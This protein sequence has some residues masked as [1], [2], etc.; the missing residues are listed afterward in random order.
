[1]PFA[2]REIWPS[3]SHKSLG[4]GSKRSKRSLQGQPATT[5]TATGTAAASVG[6]GVIQGRPS[7]MIWRL[8]NP[9]G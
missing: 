3:R 1:M 2:D 8:L 9:K 4:R 5:V 6:G 7:I